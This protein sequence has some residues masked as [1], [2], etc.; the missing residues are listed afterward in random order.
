M[1]LATYR[2]IATIFIIGL[3]IILLFD[4][5][6]ESFVTVIDISFEM[7]EFAFEF[8]IRRIFHTNHH[9]SEIILVNFYFIAA[10]GGLY[11]LWRILPRLKRYLI[12]RW[13]KHKKRVNFYWQKLTTIEKI[14]LLTAYTIGF[15]SILF[16][17][18]I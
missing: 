2:K 1:I 7:I 3:M 14:K 17:F 12:A 4:V 15:I 11:W 5:I 6:F 10:L 18:F 13:L 9:Q 16:L 8:L